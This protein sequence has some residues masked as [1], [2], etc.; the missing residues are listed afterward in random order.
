MKDGYKFENVNVFEAYSWMLFNC[1]TTCIF[2]L[3]M[4]QKIKQF[5]FKDLDT[6][7]YNSL[8][9]IPILVIISILT[10]HD[11]GLILYNKFFLNTTLESTVELCGLMFAIIVSSLFSFGISF[12]RAWAVRTSTSTTYRYYLTYYSIVGSL[13][14]LPVVVIGMIFFD[15]DTTT[16][17]V[18]GVILSFSAAVIYCYAKSI[19]TSEEQ[20]L[21]LVPLLKHEVNNNM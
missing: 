15:N 3:M 10:E 19:T 5:K 8:L 20:I 13:H 4:K 2:T 18:V 16:A 12:S 6:V 11:E 14:T 1:L 17:S 7:F 9:S 21:P